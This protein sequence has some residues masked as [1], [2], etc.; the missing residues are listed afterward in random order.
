[1]RTLGCRI[2]LLARARSMLQLSTTRTATG[3]ITLRSLARHSCL[4]VEESLCDHGIFPTGQSFPGAEEIAKAWW[5]AAFTKDRLT[6]K[7]SPM[8]SQVKVLWVGCLGGVPQHS[9]AGANVQVV[10][11]PA[12]SNKN[13]G[14]ASQCRVRAST[15]SAGARSRCAR[16]HLRFAQP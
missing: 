1:M 3:P 6:T 8:G 10:S 15:S 7:V 4:A 2:L 12:C 16:E 9:T 5:P 14:S 11:S 13:H